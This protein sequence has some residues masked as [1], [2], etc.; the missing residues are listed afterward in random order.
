MDLS[1]LR[2]PPTTDKYESSHSYESNTSTIETS[3]LCSSDTE[4]SAAIISLFNSW[5]SQTKDDVWSRNQVSNDA[6]SRSATK[7]KV[8]TTEFSKVLGEDED[9]FCDKYNEDNNNDDDDDDTLTLD[10]RFSFLPPMDHQMQIDPEALLREL[11]KRLPSADLPPPIPKLQRRHQPVCRFLNFFGSRLP[12]TGAPIPQPPSPM[13][14]SSN[15]MNDLGLNQEDALFPIFMSNT[16]YG[17]SC[18][19]AEK[20]KAKTVSDV[21]FT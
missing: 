5:S 10:D 6:W 11:R 21:D 3:S 7:A 2:Q 8:L 12:A 19:S 1:R 4:S 16:S 15:P 20:S 17:D 9:F 18:G 13:S 14:S